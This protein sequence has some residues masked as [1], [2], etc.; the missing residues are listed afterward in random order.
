MADLLTRAR[1]LE[2]ELSH[3]Q[4]Q[5]VDLQ[6]QVGRQETEL[7]K[8]RAQSGGLREERERLKAKVREYQARLHNLET[9]SPRNSTT[10]TPTKQHPANRSV[11][12][13]G[14]SPN[15]TDNQGTP[16]SK[17]AEL[18]KIKTWTTS[19]RPVLGTDITS[20]KLPMNAKVAEHLVQNLKESSDIQE[21]A[22]SANK[23]GTDVSEPRIRE[24][25]IEV[26]RLQSKIDHLKSQND[27]TCLSL[28][29]SKAH[30]DRLTVLIGKYE[31]N[32]TA[33]QLALNYCDQALEAYQ[34]LVSLLDSENSL[35][36]SKCRAAGL[37]NYGFSDDLQQSEEDLATVIQNAQCTRR[38]A[39]S[40]AK[41]LLMRLDRS[42]PSQPLGSSPNPWE[43]ISSNSRTTSSVDTEWNK[44]DEQRLRELIQQLQ[45][46]RASV[47]TTVLEL[48]SV[49]IDPML[50]E[51]PGPS[52]ESQKLD[53]ENAVLM[54][55]LMAIKREAVSPSVTVE[56]MK[57]MD[58]GQILQELHQVLHREKALKSRVKELI[59]SLEYMSQNSEYRHQQ[60]ASF[61]NDL[62]KANS[63]LI[64]AFEKA[65]KKYQAKLKK[66]ENQIQTLK[67]KY[68]DQVG[69]LVF[70][71]Q[72]LK[73]E[74]THRAASETSL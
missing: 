21:I 42:N 13:S 16:L 73:S 53:L 27:L 55:E 30:C 61:I 54:Q 45:I 59:N 29:E 65:K 7:N 32:N 6:T 44:L 57:S 12:R 66:Q 35:L 38:S 71:I 37:G 62:K 63:A 46:E 2:K 67:T 41:Q 19:D 70:T 1:Y 74:S 48:E 22:Q 33:M 64:E 52:A 31:S 58:V 23:H 72:Q 51:P 56:N 60:S 25:E 24:F 18:K 11:E 47:K 50:Q 15:L 43:D 34:V 69:S 14:S 3:L 8:L 20:M 40:I 49:H 9:T 26:E 17:M 10:S 68:E 28:G 39:E 4:Q 5:N 36:L